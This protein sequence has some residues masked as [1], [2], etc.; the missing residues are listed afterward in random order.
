VWRFSSQASNLLPQLQRVLLRT[1]PERATAISTTRARTQRRTRNWAISTYTMGKNMSTSSRSNTLLEKIL[2]VDSLPSLKA[3]Q[4]RT[5]KILCRLVDRRQMTK[6]ISRKAV[7]ATMVE[8]KWEQ[9]SLKVAIKSSRVTHLKLMLPAI[10]VGLSRMESSGDAA[11]TDQKQ[12]Q[13]QS[14]IVLRN[15]LIRKLRIM[16]KSSSSL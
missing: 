13:L 3:F 4:L 12:R 9:V 11:V 7:W 8:R 15:C 16:S 6:S 1:P 5:P 2:L 14:K 10:K